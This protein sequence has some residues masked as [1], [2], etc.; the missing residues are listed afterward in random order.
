MRPNRRRATG[1]AAMSGRARSSSRLDPGALVMVGIEGKVLD[2]AQAAIS[3]PAQIR[4]VV[5]FRSNLGTRGR[6]ARADGEL[7][8]D[9][10]AARAD[11]HRPG[12]RRGRPGDVPAAA[13]GGDGARCGRR[14]DR[15]EEVGA[16][17]AR[18]LKSLG[19]NWNFAPVLDVNNNPGQPGHR[20]AQ[21]LRRIRREVVRLA[22]AWMRGALRGRRRLL[23][24]A[25]SGTWRHARRFAPANC[26][27]ST[28]SRAAVGRAGAQALPR[29][30]KARRR[31]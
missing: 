6:S 2:A 13:A 31:R 25:F 11:R 17:V 29:A 21:L 1:M 4:A 26:R 16:A 19:F 7:A 28:R 24:Q 12:R 9:D 18:G 3:A 14:R 10:R 8:Q 27:W 20:R 23:R 15:A 30:C 22:G 5:L